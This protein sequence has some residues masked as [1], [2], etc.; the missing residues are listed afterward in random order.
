MSVVCEGCGTSNRA[1]AM[2]C[3]GCAGRL[4][5]FVATGPSALEAMGAPPSPAPRRAASGT[6]PRGDVTSMAESPAFWLTLGLAGL[7]AL[8]AA[9][10]WYVHSQRAGVGASRMDI[11]AGAATGSAKAPLAR[12]AARSERPPEAPPSPQE[13][14]DKAEELIDSVTS[15]STGTPP[16]PLTPLEPSPL[17]RN[18]I[19][20][21]AP[22]RVVA[23]FYGALAAG[24]GKTAAA[25]ITPA[26]RDIGSFSEARMTRFYGSF[27]E[28]LSVRSI[29]QID[30]NAV[31]ARYTY[32]AT[33]TLC[34]GVALVRTERI[35]EQTVIRSIRANC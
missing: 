31:E 24:D 32:R 25:I 11:A 28:P 17:A 27:S 16:A 22:S 5:T 18:D 8:A 14:L 2:F 4:P 34:E 20:P 29:R 35:A 13:W 21:D 6:V 33:R 15:R 3:I 7:A 23:A 19:G 1:T 9:T 10:G 30:A 12:P 26:K